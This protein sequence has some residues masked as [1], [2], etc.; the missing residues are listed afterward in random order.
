MAASFL[1]AWEGSSARKCPAGVE[2]LTPLRAK[3][4]RLRGRDGVQGWWPRPGAPRPCAECL[5]ALAPPLAPRVCLGA[6]VCGRGQM[7]S[8]VCRVTSERAPRG[9]APVV[10]SVLYHWTPTQSLCTSCWPWQGAGASWTAGTCGPPWLP[11]TPSSPSGHSTGQ[12]TWSRRFCW[13]AGCCRWDQPESPPLPGPLG[14]GR[15]LAGPL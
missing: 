4:P 13:E 10:P 6:Q 5:R 9:R 1:D 12:G 11:R 8:R 14:G 15:Q 2:R 7:P 3:T